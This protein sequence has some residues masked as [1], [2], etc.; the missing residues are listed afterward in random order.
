MPRGYFVSFGN[1]SGPIAAFN[2]GL[3]AQKGSLYATRPTLATY[4]ARREDLVKMADELLG[5]VRDGKI[6]V[7]PRREF[8]LREAAA[9]HRALEARETT[10]STIL[11]P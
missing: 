4:V 2:L 1:A 9:A 10:G 6:R 5:M 11:L 8:P 3:L 7:G